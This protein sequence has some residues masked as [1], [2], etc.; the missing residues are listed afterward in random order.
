MAAWNDLAVEYYY[1]GQYEKAV[2]AAREALRINPD[3]MNSYSVLA[4]NYTKQ[5]KLAEAKSVC[6]QAIERQR[7]HWGIHSS[8]Y[9]IGFLEGDTA[10]MERELEWA[11]GRPEEFWFDFNEGQRLAFHGRLDEAREKIAQ[12]SM[13]AHQRNRA[14]ST[15]LFLA[16]LGLTEAVV[17]NDRQAREYAAEASRIA[18]TRDTGPVIAL[19]QSWAGDGTQARELSATLSGKHPVDTLLQEVQLPNIRAVLEIRRGDPSRAVEL[20]QS[21]TPYERTLE[22]LWSV[23]TRGEAY[24]E[25]GKGAEAAAEFQKVLDNP[26]VVPVNIIHAIAHLGLGRA[27]ALAG[28]E[29]SARRA[30]QD[31][32]ALWK[33]ADPNIPILREAKAEYAKLR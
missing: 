9:E 6:E 5:N 33:D 29:A 14:E 24:R 1:I 12:A 11:K 30:Y 2:E 22:G 10:A 13:L 17:G 21:A 19:A 31:F 32:L 16:A 15:S 26:G 27:K 20:L 7:A 4:W 28:D 18:T 3:S 8:L 25:L 23:Y